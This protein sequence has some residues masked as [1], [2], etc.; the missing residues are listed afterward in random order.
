ME[1]VY[2]IWKSLWTKICCL[3]RLDL[4]SS[5]TWSPCRTDAVRDAAEWRQDADDRDGYVHWHAQ[6]RQGPGRHHVR[7]HQGLFAR[8]Q[9]SLWLHH[10]SGRVCS[11][12]VNCVVAIFQGHPRVHEIST[13]VSSLCYAPAHMMLSSTLLCRCGSEWVG[14]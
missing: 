6:H 2:P 8:S 11:P 1:L 10:T 3:R 9:P 12:C 13:S 14:G 5:L 7:E 4:P